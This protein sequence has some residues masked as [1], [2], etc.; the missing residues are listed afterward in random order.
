MNSRHQSLSFFILIAFLFATLAPAH[1]A[2]QSPQDTPA[3]IS[4]L[5][6]RAGH[7]DRDAQF[8][9]GYRY[10]HGQ[11]VPRNYTLALQNY[12]AAA[13]QHHSTAEN[14]LAALYQ[15]GLGVHKNIN[16]A[17]DWYL[18]SAQQGNPVAQCNLAS[19]YYLGSGTPRDFQQAI[20]WFRAAA[21]SGVAEAQD[22]LAYFYFTG[23]GIQRDYTEAARLLRLAAQQN[24]PIAQTNLAFLYEQGKGVPLNYVQAYT[25]YSQAL[26]AGDTTGADRRAQLVQIMTTKQRN[27]AAAQAPTNSALVPLQPLHPSTT[28]F[29]LL[30]H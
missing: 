4:D 21:D 8:L 24:L 19:L 1:A 17:F 30:N 28:A 14:N 2:P 9:L 7:G 16:K 29:S 3:T 10:E 20:R 13:L 26:A 15:H 22:N 12:R 18:A 27:E 5:Q 6:S 11:G 23:T 25:L